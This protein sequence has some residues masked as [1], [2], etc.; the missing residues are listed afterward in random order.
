MK[1][2]SKTFGQAYEKLVAQSQKKTTNVDQPP[3]LPID[4]I[5]TA[6]DVFQPRLWGGSE[7]HVQELSRA[8]SA[9]SGDMPSLD[10]ILVITIGRQHYCVDGHHRLMAYKASKVAYP[11]SVEYFQGTIAEAVAASSRANSRD[12]LPLERAEKL[13]AAWRLVI[14]GG[15]SK[16]Q[17]IDATGV[18][19][20]SV[21]SMRKVHA[22]LKKAFEVGSGW[23]AVTRP[24]NPADLTWSEAQRVGKPEKDRGEEW[25]DQQVQEWAA[26]LR[27]A[28]GPKWGKLPDL[29]ARAIEEFSPELPAKLIEN[30]IDT[31]REVV[32]AYGED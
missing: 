14:L 2:K 30:W 26:R 27:E 18:S 28:F 20:G 31:A 11:V 21:A 7:K 32:V 1:N 15:F 19:H 24:P 9:K 25:Q 5:K 4:K 17:T 10:P 8:L 23:N 16:Q 13:E 12:K 29:A 22:Q 6:P 3:R